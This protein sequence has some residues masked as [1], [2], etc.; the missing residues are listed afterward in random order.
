MSVRVLIGFTGSMTSVS[1]AVLIGSGKN[2][3]R[4][5]AGL[6]PVG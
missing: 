5:N 3:G 1:F 2:A 6:R 4:G